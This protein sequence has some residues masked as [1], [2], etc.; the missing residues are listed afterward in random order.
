MSRS[1]RHTRSSRWA[2]A[3]RRGSAS[4]A[5]SPSTGSPASTARSRYGWSVT[6]S[7]RPEPRD[8]AARLSPET[9]AKLDG[10]RVSEQCRTAIVLAS[11][12]SAGESH[13]ALLSRAEALAVEPGRLRLALHA[14][15]ATSANLRTTHHATLML[16]DED[17]VETAALTLESLGA[18]EIAG[19]ELALFEALVVDA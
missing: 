12:S 8:V 5:R 11:A 4:G 3:S 16:A 9:L 14:N 19:V 15:S 10:S 18:R 17:G 2:S 6:V 7:S 1:S 13:I